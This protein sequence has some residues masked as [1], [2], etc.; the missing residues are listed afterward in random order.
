MV[1]WDVQERIGHQLPRLE[2]VALGAADR[3]QRPEREAFSQLTVCQPL[4]A[5]N[6]EIGE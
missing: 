5:I 1:A 3:P 6:D 2:R 4:Q